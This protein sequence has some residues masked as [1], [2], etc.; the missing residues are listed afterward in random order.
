LAPD[1]KKKW[2]IIQWYDTSNTALL[3]PEDRKYYQ[4]QHAREWMQKSCMKML[5]ELIPELDKLHLWKLFRSARSASNGVSI[6]STNVL[7]VI[8][9]TTGLLIVCGNGFEQQEHCGISSF[10]QPRQPCNECPQYRGGGSRFR[11]SQLSA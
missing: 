9:L 2:K 6:T 7:C 11:L 8:N 3:D 1:P 10:R 5:P 4:Y